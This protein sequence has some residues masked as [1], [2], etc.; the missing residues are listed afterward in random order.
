MAMLLGFACLVAAP[1]VRGEGE[2][3]EPSKI[4]VLQLRLKSNDVSLVKASLAPGTLKMPR[5]PKEKLQGLEVRGLSEA[6][7]V[8]CSRV[9]DDPSQRRLEYEDP[10]HPGQLK[11]IVLD[12][13]DALFVVRVPWIKELSTLQFHQ[14]L[15]D[16]DETGTSKAQA[17]RRKLLGRIESLKDKI[18]EEK[19]GV[20]P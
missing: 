7:D 15:P 4:L 11:R 14:L 19:G 18:V 3:E 2:D 8:L 12:D 20:R 16:E 9:V 1:L 6:G 13:D 10:W 17:V 5:V